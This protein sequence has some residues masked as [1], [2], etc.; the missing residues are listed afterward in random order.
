M[1]GGGAK[2]PKGTKRFYGASRRQSK[3]GDGETASQDDQEDAVSRAVEISGIVEEICASEA[4]RRIRSAFSN[5]LPSFIVECHS[6]LIDSVALSFKSA[7]SPLNPVCFLSSF[8]EL[9]L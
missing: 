6:R 3:G 1:E 7:L 5:C 4:E 8:Y 2:K 9:I